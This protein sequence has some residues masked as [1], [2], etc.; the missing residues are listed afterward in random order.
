MGTWGGRRPGAG[1]KPS[2]KNRRMVSLIAA[3]AIGKPPRRCRLIS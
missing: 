2:S 1:R 3:R